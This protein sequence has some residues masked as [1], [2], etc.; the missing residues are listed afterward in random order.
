MGASC[1]RHSFV[2]FTFL[3]FIPFLINV[4]GQTSFNQT[5]NTSTVNSVPSPSASSTPPFPLPTDA[6]LTASGKPI[7]C[8]LKN[9]KLNPSTHKLVSDCAP[10][11]FCLAP[12]NSPPNATG[13]CVRRRCRRDAY[14]FGYARFGGVENGVAE[15]PRVKVKG[16]LTLVP[17]DDPLM[18]AK[19]PPLCPLERFCPDNGSGCR[20]K[21]GAGEKCELGRDEQCLDPPF[22]DAM[23]QG[24]LNRAVCLKAA[25]MYVFSSFPQN[26][27]SNGFLL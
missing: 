14:P 25:C 15:V 21:L 5:S 13:I 6:P 26:R 8:T 24:S 9:T 23:P 19:L 2:L 27:R 17:D 11:T 16:R 4:Y 18:Q 7:P 1:H 12:P 20:L 22:D 10:Q 3:S